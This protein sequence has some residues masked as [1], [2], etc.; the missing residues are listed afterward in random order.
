MRPD[1]SRRRKLFLAER[2]RNARITYVHG[3]RAVVVVEPDLASMSL[4]LQHFGEVLEHAVGKQ[5]LRV[6]K[7]LRAAIDLASELLDVS[8]DLTARMVNRIHD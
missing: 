3:Q 4:Q 8:L 1:T 2:V 5:Q 6:L 7:H